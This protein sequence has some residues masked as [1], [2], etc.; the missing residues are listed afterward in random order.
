[1][2]PMI[3]ELIDYRGDC[4]KAYLDVSLCLRILPPGESLEFIVE[5]EKLEKI[6]K[7]IAHNNGEVLEQT[8]S[9]NDIC[10]KVRK[11]SETE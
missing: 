6:K 8:F 5:K 3:K 10:L 1:M 9:D 11:V 4:W 7:V 2:K